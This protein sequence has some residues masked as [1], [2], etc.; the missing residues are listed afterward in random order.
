MKWYTV[1]VACAL[2]VAAHLEGEAMS[3]LSNQPVVSIEGRMNCPYISTRGGTAYLQVSIT[4]AGGGRTER[5]PLNLS[6]VLDRSGSM[7]EESKIQNA[8]AALSTLVDQLESDD[9]LSIVIYDDVVEVLRSASRVGDKRLIKRLIDEVQP[10]GFTNLGGG[11]VEGF[12][13]VERNLHRE[14]VNRVIL[15][16]DGLAN[17]GITDPA[18]LNRV[19]RKYR[20]RSISITTMGVGLDYNENLMVSLAENGGGNYYFIESSRHLASVLRREFDMLSG[21]VAQNATLDLN[22]GP[23]VRI[24]DVIGFEVGRE[25]NH[26]VVPVGDLYT[27]DRRE[28]TVELD[29][30]SGSGSFSAVSGILRYESEAGRQASC[31]FS[32]H[33]HYTR[34]VAEIERNRDQEAQARADVA[35]S[36]RD[37]DRA[38]KA[39]DEG[40]KDEAAAR[41]SQARQTLAASPAATVAGS[42]GGAIREQQSK[43]ISFESLLSDSSGDARKAKKEIQY[44]NYQVQKNKQ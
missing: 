17:R 22:A 32:A 5:Q 2:G 23:G 9:I 44:R 7:G 1:L 12:H 16:S 40:K 39:L 26:I 19:V 21:V 15:L 24:V 33:I 8:K 29:V 4:T 41:L 43:I 18:E 3:F 36:T 6:V 35:V 20:G 31:G 42:A 14:Y 34:D 25:G 30:P 38:M 11:M 27:R 28:F 10:R 37:V 13:Q